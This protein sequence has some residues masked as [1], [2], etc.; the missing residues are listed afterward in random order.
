[1]KDS[2]E[3]RIASLIYTCYLEDTDNEVVKKALELTCLNKSLKLFHAKE[4]IVKI[5]KGKITYFNANFI[6]RIYLLVVKLFEKEFDCS[7]EGLFL[8][9]KNQIWVYIIYFLYEIYGE[10]QS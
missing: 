2:L 3:S 6:R 4:N 5:E 1:M 10:S 8:A 7:N 9:H